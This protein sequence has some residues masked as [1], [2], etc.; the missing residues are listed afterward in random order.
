MSCRLES[1][2]TFQ[3]KMNL[4]SWKVL[5]YYF[6]AIKNIS[7]GRTYIDEINIETFSKF[8]NTQ[9]IIAVPLQNDFN[10][11]LPGKESFVHFR[12]LYVDSW[13]SL[14]IYI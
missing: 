11:V 10:I 4:C 2:A 14:R 3:Y 7:L 9:L 6:Y 13:N 5:Q 8:Y 1:Y 12:I